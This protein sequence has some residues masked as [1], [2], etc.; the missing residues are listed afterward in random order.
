MKELI[1][2]VNGTE[3]KTNDFVTRIVTNVLTGVLDSLKLD[4]VPKSA[5]FTISEKSD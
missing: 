3:I 4:E 1:L 5:V 2:T